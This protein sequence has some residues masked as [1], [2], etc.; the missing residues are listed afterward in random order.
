MLEGSPEPLL[1][2]SSP[3][4]A[5]GE[6]GDDS[7]AAYAPFRDA[8]LADPDVQCT[9]YHVPASGESR[10]VLTKETAHLGPA[11]PQSAAELLAYDAL[12]LANVP[13]AAL[14]DQV[15]GWVEEW[16]G[17]RGGGLLMAG[18]PRSFGAGGWTGT[19]VERMLPVEFLG[20]PD[21]D[22]APAVLEP[23]GADLHPMWR[24]FEDEQPRA[25]CGRSRSRWGAAT[26]A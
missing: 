26:G 17:K 14:S 21:W 6:P 19:A 3:A 20:S 15:L 24:L 22:A 5:A 13:R 9:V 1:A 12:V 11:F 18:G 4:R 7:D 2:R 8:L 25:A 10:R 23:T 16:I